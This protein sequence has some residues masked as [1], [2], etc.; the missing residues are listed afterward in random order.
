MEKAE[1]NPLGQAWKIWVDCLDGKDINSIFQQ[2]TLMIWDTAIFRLIL[3]GRQTQ[4]DK[5]PEAPALNGALHSFIDRNYFQSQVSFIRRLIDKSNQLIGPRAVYSIYALINDIGDRR[6]EL[7]REAFFNLRNMSYDF[8]EIKAREQEFIRKQPV[9]AGFIRVPHEYDWE[10]ISEAHVTFDRLSGK[11][12]KDRQ[13]NDVIPE[14]VFTRL[15]DKLDT[16]RNITKYVDKFIAHSATPESRAI[17][18]VGKSKITFNHLWEAHHT[19]FELAEF[20]STILFS[21]G[22]MALAIENSDFFQYWDTPMFEEINVDRIRNTLEKYRKET[23]E[24]N[25]DGIEKTWKWIE[26]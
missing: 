22:H 8:L 10:S 21:E 25:Q 7:T 2:I 15:K 17:Q 18:N 16:C 12:Q 24:W 9:G 11:T 3:E 19:I 14:R 13:P 1:E 20:L 5:N 26:T 6:N 23:E 4:I